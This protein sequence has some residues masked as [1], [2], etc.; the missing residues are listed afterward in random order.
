[1]ARLMGA[2]SVLA[3]LRAGVVSSLVELGAETD[4]VLAARDLDG[5]FRIMESLR[6]TVD[7]DSEEEDDEWLHASPSD[8]L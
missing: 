4:D 1:M 3:G 8:Q 7:Q 5:A 2:R 6:V